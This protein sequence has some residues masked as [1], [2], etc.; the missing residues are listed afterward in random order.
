MKKLTL[1]ALRGKLHA[2]AFLRVNYHGWIIQRNRAAGYDLINIVYDDTA[3]LVGTD[4]PKRIGSFNKW[5]SGVE[6]GYLE[7]VNATIRKM[8]LSP[9]ALVMNGDSEGMDLNDHLGFIGDVLGKNI[10]VIKDARRENSFG[11]YVLKDDKL[12]YVHYM[13]SIYK[14]NTGEMLFTCFEGEYKSIPEY[15]QTYAPVRMQFKVEYNLSG[16]VEHHDGD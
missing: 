10:Q 8:Y 15:P 3:I 4:D 11:H 16:R 12:W 14:V 5:M 9:E 2:M 7:P 1:E 6:K 13:P